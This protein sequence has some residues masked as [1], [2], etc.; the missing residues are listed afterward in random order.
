M[1]NGSIGS[2]IGLPKVSVV[3]PVYNAEDTVVDCIDSVLGQ[4]FPDLEII[5]VDDGSNDGSGVLCDNCARRDSRVKVIHQKNKGRSAARGVGTIMSQAKWIG[6]VDSDDTLPKDAISRLYA[7]AIDDVD[8]VLGNGYKFSKG[9]RCPKISIEE[10]RHMVV[11]AEGPIGVPWGCLFRRS[12]LTSWVWDIPRE[13]NM[14]EDYV[15]WLRVIFQTRKP[16]NVIYEKVY[17]K[18]ADTTCANFKWNAGYALAIHE[19]R[20]GAIPEHLWAT[21]MSDT[22]SDR[23]VNLLDVAC[24]QP[25]RLWRHSRFYMELKED[26][27]KYGYDVP[28]KTKIYLS[29]PSLWMRRMYSKLSDLKNKWI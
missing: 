24:C 6:Y 11:R 26:I 10:F 13:I 28:L 3:I 16:V 25:C 21:Y 4:D 12:V 22:I 27:G 14:G 23:L 2:S 15:F 18:G 8:V 20:K 9:R 29:L 1:V 5:V 17:D 19:L 7:K